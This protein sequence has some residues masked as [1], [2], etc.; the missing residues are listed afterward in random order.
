MCPE[1]GGFAVD[2]NHYYEDGIRV[3]VYE[4]KNAHQWEEPED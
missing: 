3:S 4:C 1:C 2:E